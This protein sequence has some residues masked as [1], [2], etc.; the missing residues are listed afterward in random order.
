MST[1]YTY[2]TSPWDPKFD[3]LATW[4]GCHKI[5]EGQDEEEFKERMAKLQAEYNAQFYQRR[6]EMKNKPAQALRRK[7]CQ[8]ALFV[9]NMIAL[10]V[11]NISIINSMRTT[12]NL[13]E[14]VAK[15][16]NAH[17]TNTNYF[18]GPWVVNK[19]G[20][21]FRQDYTGRTNYISMN[22]TVLAVM[23]YNKCGC[24][25]SPETAKESCRECGC[26]ISISRTREPASYD[27]DST[28]FFTR[29]IS[30]V[31]DE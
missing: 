9:V 6:Q 10:M 23:P 26:I 30:E 24:A 25:M 17:K 2:D 21:E 29:P 18:D 12:A 8:Y 15:L 31:S 11:M 4:N 14:Q 5:P 13:R 28:F 20:M 19:R 27:P 3:E 1:I 22:G 16:R 7:R